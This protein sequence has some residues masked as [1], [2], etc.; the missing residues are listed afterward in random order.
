MAKT[1]HQ[2]DNFKKR[3]LMLLSNS[4]DPDPR[5]HREAKALVDAGYSVTILG[6]DRDKNTRKKEIIDGIQVERIYVKS[7]HGRGSSQMFFLVLFWLKAFWLGLFKK[8]DIVHAHDFDTLPLGYILAKV[9]RAK[10]VYDSHESYVDMLHTLPAIIRKTVFSL[11][12]YFMKRVDL[13]ITVGEILRNYLQE[14]GARNICI[15]GNWQ[16]PAAFNF[17]Q[18]EIQAEKNRL[19]IGKS[20]K[21]ITF[22]ANLGKERRVEELIKAVS[23]TPDSYLILGGDG[24][25]SAE[26]NEAAER[27]ENIAYLGRVAP[28]RVPF[29]TVLGDIIYY[30]FDPD[31]PNARFSA[32]N[33]LF[34]CLA[35]GRAVLT[36]DFGE[37]G[38]IV[39]ENE[40]GVIIF[41]YSI[42]EITQAI[43]AMSPEDLAIYNR[44]SLVASERFY[45]WDIAKESLLSNYTTISLEGENNK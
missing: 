44:N 45:S 42:E 5:V 41:D 36:A 12:N 11:E 26:A 9:K 16:D 6:W 28:E 19:G 34:E 15:V 29:Y 38:K 31:N 14:R 3:I 1:L 20:Q 33:K 25:C 2:P 27:F 17:T 43:N 35:A 8:F 22:I 32:P 18:A 7:T 30:G 40:C 13:V 4:F 37:I 21:V 24:A 23:L 39:K 10:I